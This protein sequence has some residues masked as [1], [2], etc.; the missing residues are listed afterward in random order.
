[1]DR[2]TFVSELDREDGRVCSSFDLDE[3][4]ARLAELEAP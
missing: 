4:R 1:M 3:I 2:N